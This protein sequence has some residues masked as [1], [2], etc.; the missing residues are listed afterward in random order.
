MT[1]WLEQQIATTPA[2][3]EIVLE[4]G[5]V[6][7]WP[8]TIDKPL[9]IRGPGQVTLA[10]ANPPIVRGNLTG[11][12]SGLRLEGFW[13]QGTD[14][15]VPAFTMKRTAVLRDLRF[16]G[17]MLDGVQISATAAGSNPNEN[18]NGWEVSNV[19]VVGAARDGLN[20]EGADANAGRS[21]GF[22]A[23]ACGRHGL[24]D[25]SFLGNTHIAAHVAESGA[26]SY[27][28]TNANA[29]T[30][31]LGCYAEKGQPVAEFVR[32]TMLVNCSMPDLAY[33]GAITVNKDGGVRSQGF[34]FDDGIMRGG[35]GG[36]GPNG[37]VLWWQAPG[38]SNKYRLRL[39]G[40][41]YE[42]VFANNA[43]NVLLRLHR[44]TAPDPFMVTA[45]HG[46]GI[47]G[48]GDVKQTRAPEAP[49][50][51]TWAGRRYI[52]NTGPDTSIKGWWLVSPGTFG[53]D[54]PPVFAADYVNQGSGA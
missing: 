49:T 35:I 7:D 25:S 27:K 45:P 9:T 11:W 38:D 21:I 1:G 5:V 44:E 4:A 40:N 6:Y 48:W 46:L 20:I 51:G 19:L 36:N 10:T 43:N 41:Y 39:N 16:M 37:D 30:V 34:E 42:I 13:W 32:P 28:T 47:G 23:M 26:A 53:T 29:N 22:N 3:G 18:A 12:A 17:L 31:L 50:T 33:K 52:W 14:A 24:I 2:G 54:T 15:T 8:A